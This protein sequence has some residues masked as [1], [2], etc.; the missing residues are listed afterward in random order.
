MSF[1]HLIPPFAEV[2]VDG[3]GRVDGKP[4]VGVDGHAEEAR[5]GVDQFADVPK[6]KLHIESH[7]TDLA[8]RLWSTLASLR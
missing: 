5:V 1:S 7:G 6:G 8:L 4:L 3:C 2:D